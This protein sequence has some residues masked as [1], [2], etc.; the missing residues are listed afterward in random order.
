MEYDII[1]GGNVVQRLRPGST[2]IN[3]TVYA[4]VLRPGE[5]DTVIRRSPHNIDDSAART[6]LKYIRDLCVEPMCKEE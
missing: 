1:D 6:E 2:A 5:D 3:R 4:V